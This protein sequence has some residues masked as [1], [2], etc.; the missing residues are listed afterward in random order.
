MSQKKKQAWDGQR[1]WLNVGLTVSVWW[2]EVAPVASSLLPVFFPSGEK[3][4]EGGSSKQRSWVVTCRWKQ[5]AK[6]GGWWWFWCFSVV[7]IRLLK[8]LLV[9]VFLAKR[10]RAREREREDWMADL[11]WWNG[12][13]MSSIYSPMEA[14][15]TI[16]EHDSLV[17]Q[18]HQQHPCFVPLKWEGKGCKMMVH[19]GMAKRRSNGMVIH[20]SMN[21]WKYMVMSSLSKGP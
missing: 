7:V 21:A 6:G 1:W 16:H 15:K 10:K 8:P 4:E 13:E 2:Q 12:K 17:S 11:L 14:C 3:R 20:S 19:V 9:V 18:T 5:G